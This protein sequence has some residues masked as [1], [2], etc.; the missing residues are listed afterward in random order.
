MSHCDTSLHY[1][2]YIF[3]ADSS[4]DSCPKDPLRYLLMLPGGC[5]VNIE[6]QDMDKVDVGRCMDTS[7]QRLNVDTSTVDEGC[8]GAVEQD[9]LNVTC[10][11]LSFPVQKITRCGC[12][13]CVTEKQFATIRGQ[14]YLATFEGGAHVLNQPLAPISF[15]VNGIT[16]TA[17]PSGEF[18]IGAE[19]ITDVVSLIFSPTALDTY[20]PHIVTLSLIDGVSIYFVTVKLPP[21]PAPLSLDTTKDNQIL[22]G[23][24]Q[25]DSPLV[26]Q[27][28]ANSFVD[29]NG[30][31]VEEEIDVFVT[32]MNSNSSLSLAP[33]EFTYIDEEGFRKRLITYGVINMQAM[34]KSGDELQLSGDLQMEIDATALGMSPENV[35]DTSTW[36][37]DEDTGFW[38]NPV[39]LTGGGGNSR[40]KRQMLNPPLLSVLNAGG[41]TF[42]NLDRWHFAELCKVLVVPYDF[43]GVEPV[44]GVQIAVYSIVT[45]AGAGYKQRDVRTTDANGKACG[46]V[47]CGNNFEIFEPSGE[48]VPTGGHCLPQSFI[49]QNALDGGI[50]HIYG[51]AP[52]AQQLTGNSQGPVYLEATGTCSALVKQQLDFTCILPP[53]YYHFHFQ[54]KAQTPNQFQIDLFNANGLKDFRDGRV[55]YIRMAFQVSAS[56]IIKCFLTEYL[57][58][59][60]ILFPQSFSI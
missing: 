28:P 34:T 17:S 42:W 22:S 35:D 8:C 18:K 23:P 45:G 25:D 31:A 20:M 46:W 41:K 4:D 5:T 32:F 13:S 19:R 47:E 1:V 51:L 24:T 11:L 29:A 26:I 43:F 10:N 53:P 56:S 48:Y 58:F 59:G 33:G 2:P 30:D 60:W 3:H 37:M 57:Y 49:F 52:T 9:E 14:I 50:R 39:P 15:V 12:G 55:C 7:C 36:Q 38:K 16:H 27:V 21:K 40:K 44:P 54:L 6:G